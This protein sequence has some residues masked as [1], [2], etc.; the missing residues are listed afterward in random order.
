MGD[1]TQ[2]V[3]SLLARWGQG[4]RQALDQLTPLVYNEL[5]RLAKAYLR[6]ERPDHT[7]E[8][9]ALVHEAYLRLIDQRQ[10]EWKSRNQFFGL[11]AELIRRILVDHA[12]A[13]VAAKRGGGSF[14]LSLDDAIAP[15]QEQD[16]DL[17]ALDDALQ[18]LART[19]PQ[20]SRIVELR[21]F[22]GLT[23]EET[24]QVLDI[25]AATIKRDW[26]MAKAFLKREMLRNART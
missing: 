14:K 18:A 17:V 12:R 3:T 16:L 5:R 4:D 10:V 15:P 25:S 9:T 13:R 7:L 26:V 23:I 19:D 22:G 8:G 21:Y 2:D 11:A 1:V 24:A 20:Q 6:R